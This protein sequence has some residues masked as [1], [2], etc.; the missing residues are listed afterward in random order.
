[1]SSSHT[2]NTSIQ[3]RQPIT[4]ERAIQLLKPLADYFGWAPEKISNQS[5]QCAESITLIRSR[6]RVLGIELH[7][8]HDAN[9][10]IYEA[11]VQFAKGLEQ[12]TVPGFIDIRNYDA[13]S[14]DPSSEIIWFGPAE[15]VKAAQNDAMR[16]RAHGL[17]QQSG[18]S[19]STMAAIDSVVN[20]YHRLPANVREPGLYQWHAPTGEVLIGIV[21]RDQYGKL[22]GTFIDNQGRAHEICF[23]ETDP[24]WC[25]TYFG[26]VRLPIFSDTASN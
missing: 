16:Q 24:A 19:L 14:Q 15:E 5:V 7:A 22:R 8:K 11:V 21:R 6:G 26:P 3:F 1:M 25:G 10:D 23:H 20:A 17:L 13:T 4:S 18:L 12:F 2:I 9:N